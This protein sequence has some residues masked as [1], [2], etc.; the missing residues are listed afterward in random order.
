MSHEEILTRADGS[1][2]KIRISLGMERHRDNAE[3]NVSVSICP[4]RKRTWVEAVNTDSNAYRSIP[5]AS[6]ERDDY[7]MG[8]YLQHCTKEE[9]H[10]AKMNLWNKIKPE[11]M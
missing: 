8:I 5:F 9:I 3:W 4:P 2:V 7:R 11:L 10:N 6:K 1:K